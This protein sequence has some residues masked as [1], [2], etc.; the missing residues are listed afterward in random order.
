CTVT[1]AQTEGPYFVERALERSD[2]RADPEGGA[3]KPGVPLALA[4]RVMAVSGKGCEPLAGA[5]VDVW[6]C[7][8][9]GAYSGVGGN[10]ERFLR[11]YQVSDA[12][13]RVRFMTIYPG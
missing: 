13:G 9:Q 1:P 11:G 8:A 12:Q 3:V 6:H 2:I 10:R 7:D 5:L 4:L